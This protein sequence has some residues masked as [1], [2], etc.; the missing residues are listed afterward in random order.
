MRRI[1]LAKGAKSTTTTIPNQFIDD[2]MANTNGEFVKVYLYLLRHICDCD[3]QFS[4]ATIADSLNHTERDI[5]RALK[6]WETKGL[7]SL[8]YTEGGELSGICLP[9]CNESC[10]LYEDASQLA[11]EA[12]A[13]ICEQAHTKPKV[14]IASEEQDH[15]YSKDE[16]NSF[17]Q[18][19]SIRELLYIAETYLG[20]TLSAADCQTIFMLYDRLKFGTDLIEYLI[21]YCVCNGSKGIRYIEKTGLGWHAEGIRTVEDAKRVQALSSANHRAVKKAFGLTSRKLVKSEVD[22]ISKWSSAYGFTTEIIEE[23]CNRTILTTHQPSFVYADK[24][25][26]VWH[27]QHVKD[28]SDIEKLDALHKNKQKPQADKTICAKPGGFNNFPARDYDY[29]KLVGDLVETTVIQ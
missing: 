23:A 8:E 14:K 2:Y 11:K 10:I 18:D 17:K 5:M 3:V 16:I 9:E 22:F 26:S 28:L 19:D 1:N 20:R 4:V 15:I 27:D 12:D 25:L 7:L 13:V 29:S 24:I 21:E 6:Y